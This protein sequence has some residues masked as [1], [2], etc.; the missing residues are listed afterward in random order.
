[1]RAAL[2]AAAAGN[3]AGQRC[4]FLNG[5]AGTGKTKPVYDMLLASVRQHGRV[6]LAMAASGIAALLLPGGTT[7]HVRMK[8]PIK[9][10]DH[11]SFCKLPKSM[12]PPAAVEVI[13]AAD[14]LLTN[15]SPMMHKHCFAAIDRSLRELTGVDKP[16]GGKVVVFGG[17]FRQTLPVVRHGQPADCVDT[18]LRRWDSWGWFKVLKLTENVRVRNAMTIGGSNAE[19]LRKYDAWL[20]QLSDGTLPTHPREGEAPHVSDQ[21]VLIPQEMVLPEDTSVEE[22][23]R[24][25]Y[26]DDS[27]VFSST[28]PK[29]LVSHTILSPRN[30][31]VDEVNLA[32]LKSFPLGVD[33]VSSPA[34]RTYYSADS[35]KEA[36]EEGDGGAAAPKQHGMN[37]QDLYSVEF[38]NFI[39]AGSLPQHKLE[40]KKGCIMMLLR[41]LNPR[42]GLANGTRVIV[43]NMYNHLVEVQIFGGPHDGKVAL[44]PRIT[45]ACEDDLPFTLHRRQFPLKLAF[46]MSN[47]KSQGQTLRNV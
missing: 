37:D 14:L 28:D 10:L 30:K 9:G 38:L 15:E 33:T 4:F 43:K 46:A 35:V 20:Q 5:P 1:V 11:K 45:N 29:F 8:I 18:C 25:A 31:D 6:A 22:L 16:F 3:G 42:E 12:P 23:I 41:N 40:M 17:D 44:I 24:T 7:A 32:A 27:G 19:A 26:G 36:R 2:D 13:L 34:E 21:A 47:N 39:S